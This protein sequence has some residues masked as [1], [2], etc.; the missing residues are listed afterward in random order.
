MRKVRYTGGADSM[1]LSAEDM[2]K[3]G[4]DDHPGYWWNQ[5]QPVVE[6]EDDDLADELIAKLRPR[7][8]LEP[9]DEELAEGLV[10]EQSRDDLLDEAKAL[11]LKGLSKASKEELAEA[12]VEEQARLDAERL[13][14][15]K[16]GE[17]TDLTA[18][19]VGAPSN[20]SGA[21]AQPSA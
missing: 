17:A 2:A 5:D 19:Q 18:D 20:A 11:G 21:D 3:L 15:I 1:V 12:I 9:T 4:F 10:E 16:A 6:I 13:E 7:F 8:K 14:Q